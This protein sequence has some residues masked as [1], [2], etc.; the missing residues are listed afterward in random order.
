MSTVISA[1]TGEPGDVAV[2]EEQRRVLVLAMPPHALWHEAMLA[3][4]HR[5]SPAP[6]RIFTADRMGLQ[7]VTWVGT[8]DGGDVNHPVFG[9]P[10]PTDPEFERYARAHDEDMWYWMGPRHRVHLV[11]PLPS[12]PPPFEVTGMHAAAK[13]EVEKGHP[14]THVYVVLGASLNRART[15]LLEAWRETCLHVQTEGVGVGKELP[16]PALVAAV[17]PASLAADPAF[18]SAMTKGVMNYT[19]TGVN[20][21][22]NRMLLNERTM[23][24]MG[25]TPAGEMPPI[26]AALGMM[27]VL[28]SAALVLSALM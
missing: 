20:T 11:A 22:A 1:R 18:S 28:S 7:E 9:A 16:H 6:Q 24:V 15:E 12:S 8:E 25:Y 13:D 10:D 17:L 5:L 21:H 23:E 3:Q 26:E 19:R 2:Q 4:V 14:D 27:L